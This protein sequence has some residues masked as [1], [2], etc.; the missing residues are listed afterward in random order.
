MSDVLTRDTDD[1]TYG[2]SPDPIVREAHRRFDRCQKWEA[3]A[4][5]RWI[6]DYKFANGD[7]DNHYQWPDEIYGQRENEAAPTLTISKVRQHNLQIIND[8]KQRKSSIKYRPVGDGA[9]AK[10]A[11]VYEG[12]VR[13][14]ENV[15]NASVH[16]GMAIEFQ[17]QAGLGFTRVTTDYEHDKTF[18]Q[19]IYIR[20]IPD[21]SACYL[22]PDAVELDG[23]D[24][25][26]GFVFADRPRAAVLK[27]YPQ[28]EGK[29]T[30][31]NAVDGSSA[32][33]VREKTVRE[34]E[35]YVIVE[36]ED[37][38]LGS[39]DGDVILRSAINAKLLRE[40]EAQ[41]EADGGEL[42]RRPV[43]T[44][45]LKWYKIIGD[46]VVDEKD[47]PG[48]SVPIVPWIGEQTVIDNVLDRKGH[49]RALKDAQR[50]LNYNRSASVQYGALQGK[51]PW[52]G[53]ARAIEGYETYWQ[54]ANRENHAIL[55][56][57]D[58]DEN[59]QPIERPTRVEPP[60]SAPAFIE[61]AT[62]AERDMMIASGQ[63]EAEMGAPSNEVS[64]R[65]INERQRQGDRATYHFTDQQA[66]AIR[67]EGQILLELI[68]EVYDTRRVK[69]ILGE[70]GTEDSVTIDPQ[71]QGACQVTENGVLFNPRVG[72]YAV[73]SDVGPDYATQRQEAFQAIV[74]ILTQA[75][76][77]IDRVGDLL[78]RVAD[79]PLA[80]EMAERLKP[81][82]SPEAA[83]AVDALQKQLQIAQAAGAN[84]QRLLSEAMQ[85]L[86]EERL[87]SK[88]RDQEAV[89]DA[90]DA[91]TKRL[92][93]LKDALPLDPVALQALIRE[94][95]RQ[96]LQDNLGPAVMSAQPGLQTL[97]AGGSLPGATGAVP[98]T[99]TPG[100]PAH[101][102]VPNVGQQAATPG[103]A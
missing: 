62:A 71:C 49:T 3:T 9:T 10:A 33:W 18:D 17:V 74:Q 95:V 14:I 88:A 72:Q 101:P 67:R 7:S 102:L 97:A 23:S 50:M 15:S 2:I 77:L 94:T 59:G 28:L 70:D 79:F 57:N 80:D 68:A 73:V 75:P 63:Y 8:A 41:V 58:V 89:I 61:G 38:L 31:T 46:H 99:G 43:V 34:C 44:K 37:E 91:D 53:S 69:R 54:T 24:A 20:G 98:I 60:A 56:Y 11:E 93:A 32:G 21:P 76:Q 22:D 82:L 90:F 47:P 78:F 66:I 52:M 13:H 35:Y 85:S 65:A 55:P 83:K 25:R 27:E 45:R 86:T 6:D 96:A 39:P 30:T 42:K 36:T 87:K 64:G 29:I 1:N 16:R 51:M 40:W 26:Y 84:A 5:L 4:R 12:I 81:G 19:E 103:G 92:S 48:R 100:G